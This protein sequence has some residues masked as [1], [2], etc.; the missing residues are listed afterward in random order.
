M[1]TPAF[2]QYRS[3][4][5][6]IRP[7]PPSTNSY[8]PSLP[9]DWPLHTCAL[10]IYARTPF[11]QVYACL[12]TCMSAHTCVGHNTRVCSMLACRHEATPRTT[13]L[14]PES[15]D[16]SGKCVGALRV[17]RPVSRETGH[18]VC[19]ETSSYGGKW[20]ARV[21]C[22]GAEMYGHIMYSNNFFMCSNNYLCAVTADLYHWESAVPSIT[23]PFRRMCGQFVR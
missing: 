15:S 8:P 11:G 19:L 1:H 12:L 7:P 23:R 4:L 20:S 22:H 17:Y 10:C 5:Y 6:R 9:H 2:S 13:F 16:Y 21:S 14:S 3:S 18:L